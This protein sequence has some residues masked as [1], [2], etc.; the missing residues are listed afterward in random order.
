MRMLKEFFPEFVEKFD[1][2]D[3]LYEEIVAP[4]KDKSNIKTII[5]TNIVDLVKL[6]GLK[7]F[8]GKK[9]SG[10]RFWVELPWPPVEAALRRAT[11]SSVR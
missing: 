9:I 2:I 11:R 5:A 4:I 7:K 6:S 3:K 10:A 1:E 8:L